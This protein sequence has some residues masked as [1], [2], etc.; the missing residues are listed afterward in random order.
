MRNT[1]NAYL[2]IALTI[3]SLALSGCATIRPTPPKND[4]GNRTYSGAQKKEI[5]DAAK[6]VIRLIDPSKTKIFDTADGFDAQRAKVSYY[7][8][9]SGLDIFKFKFV[10]IESKDS[11]QTTFDVD[12]IIS[13]ASFKTLGMPVT[14]TGKPE[15]R[16]VYDLFYS[17][18]DYLLGKNEKWHNCKDA[19]NKIPAG[20]EKSESIEKIGLSSFCGRFVEDVVPSGKLTTGNVFK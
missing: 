3:S 2:I 6:E 11:I 4:W 18:V 1:S 14:N 10:A 15:N 7:V 5:I 19:I 13:R 8:I 9:E 20:I 12:E 17:R 16:Y